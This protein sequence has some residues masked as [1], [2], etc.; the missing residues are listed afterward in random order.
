M[1]RL[2]AVMMFVAVMFTACNKDTYHY[3]DKNQE[4]GYGTL[5][6]ANAELI[7]SEEL[8]EITRAEE[9]SAQELDNY[10]IW[11]LKNDGNDTYTVFDLDKEDINKDYVVYSSVKQDGIKLEAGNY[12]LKIQFLSIDIPGAAFETPIY[13]AE[14][15]FNIVAGSDTELEHITCKL[16]KQVAVVVDYN[17]LFLEH[18]VGAG[19]T[20]V[21]RKDDS[22]SKLVYEVVGNETASPVSQTDDKGYFLISDVEETLKVEF[23]GQMRTDDG[24]VKT[25]KMATSIGGVKA[26]QLRK[27]KFIMSEDTDG[28][29]TFS[30]E[31]NGM[32][33]DETLGEGIDVSEGSLGTDP[34]APKGDGNIRLINTAGLNEYTSPTMEAWNGSFTYEN[35]D[36]DQDEE[37]RNDPIIIPGNLTTNGVDEDGKTKYLLSFDAIVPNGIKTFVVEIESETIVSQLGVSKLDLI[38]DTAI[39]KNI[40]GI[41]PFPYHDPD[42]GK[43]IQDQTTISFELGAAV[44]LLQG[45]GGTHIFRMKVR[46]NQDKMKDIDLKLV[47]EE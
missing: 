30:I 14:I 37:V 42:E 4:L 8:D 10:C 17:E 32:V 3:K 20:T 2:F 33:E 11:V 22:E 24:N 25:Q 21:S 44:P 5:S 39:L 40:S 9:Q 26:G 1:K 13:G 41:I 36:D 7:V 38:N 31:I 23:K 19:Q 16:W 47:V 6:F 34:N 27:I 18:L 29:A 35:E 15:P 12:I 43:Y 45:L 46:D 28:N